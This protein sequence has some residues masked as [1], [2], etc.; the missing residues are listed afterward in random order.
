M[1]GT[2]HSESQF[3]TGSLSFQTD[4]KWRLHRGREDHKRLARLFR[5]PKAQFCTTKSRP[6][7]LQGVQSH[8]LT[9]QHLPGK[10]V[11]HGRRKCLSNANS[12]FGLILAQIV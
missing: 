6:T 12:A 1:R 9:S 8:P 5:S 2:Q 4:G 7:L 11:T 10:K 3:A